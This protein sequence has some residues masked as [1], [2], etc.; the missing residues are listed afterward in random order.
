MSEVPLCAGGMRDATLHGAR[1]SV[2]S[3]SLSL[4]LS[5]SYFLSLSLSLYAHTFVSF[6]VCND[7]KC[8]LGTHFVI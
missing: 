5:L 1:P 8:F 3:L 2:I 7:H 6:N 4:S